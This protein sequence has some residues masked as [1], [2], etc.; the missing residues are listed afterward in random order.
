MRTDRLSGAVTDH[1]LLSISVDPPVLPDAVESHALAT[2]R[3][4]AL[5]VTDDRRLLL[6]AC[7]VA[8]EREL[9]RVVWPGSQDPMPAA[10]TSTSLVI[11]RDRDF[12]APLCSLYPETFAQALTSVRLWDDDAQDWTTLAAS[13]TTSNGYRN[14]PGARILVDVAGQY[15]I[16][17]SLTAP[18]T[19][20]PNAIEAVARA[21]AYME[22]LRPG[23]LSEIAGEQ[24][25]LAGAMMKSGA[26]EVLRAEKWRVTL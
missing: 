10:R 2:S 17:A 18:T 5:T 4:K 7:A 16:V 22:T 20:P 12:A 26:A 8:V 11:V 3:E 15:E 19:A 25:V 6:A 14:A 24:Q 13:T 21:W 9:L 23:D 1:E